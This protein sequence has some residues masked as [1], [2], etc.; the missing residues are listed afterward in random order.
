MPWCKHDDVIKRNV[1]R[2]T[3]HLCGEFTGQRWIHRTK[4]R[5]GELWCFLWSEPELRLSNHG[6]GW[7]FETP[8]RPLWRHFNETNMAFLH[9]YFIPR[10][11][12]YTYLTSFNVLPWIQQQFRI[13]LTHTWYLQG[14]HAVKVNHRKWYFCDVLFRASNAA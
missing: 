4:A 5:D 1:F 3:G 9:T 11:L 13:S 7:W 10:P 12:V 6:W 8:S 2:V 14:F